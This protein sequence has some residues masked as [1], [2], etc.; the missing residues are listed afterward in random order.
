MPAVSVRV[1]KRSRRPPVH[2][3][4]RLHLYPAIGSQTQ[5]PRRPGWISARCGMRRKSPSL[6]PGPRDPKMH[7]A[8]S[9]VCVA[10]RRRRR[11]RE[12]RTGEASFT[13]LSCTLHYARAGY[14]GYV[15]VPADWGS[16]A[17]WN[18]P[19]GQ[20]NDNWRHRNRFLHASEVGLSEPFIRDV[21]CAAERWCRALVG[22]ARCRG[23]AAASSGGG[24]SRAYPSRCRA[25]E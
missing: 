12:G 3:A 1:I 6:V 18:T 11:G 15:G 16:F 22:S 9:L 17:W 10:T 19:G 8:L 4:R 21:G 2:D 5:P 23:A 7:S 25:R 14:G 13:S 20:W 24:A